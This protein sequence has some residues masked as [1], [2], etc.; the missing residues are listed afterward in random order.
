MTLND[1]DAVTDT[2]QYI[3][4]QKAED[5]YTHFY[6]LFLS[7]LQVIMVKLM[8]NKRFMQVLMRINI[9]NAEFLKRF[10]DF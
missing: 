3:S 4:L 10:I 5:I 2:C 8:K 7:S 9:Q 6:S 1:A